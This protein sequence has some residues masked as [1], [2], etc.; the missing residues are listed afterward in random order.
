[1]ADITP[2]L[3]VLKSYRKGEGQDMQAKLS[4]IGKRFRDDMRGCIAMLAVA[5]R[6]SEVLKGCLEAGFPFT[7]Q[8][9]DVTDEAEVRNDDPETTRVIRESRFRKEYGP[10]QVNADGSVRDRSADAK[11]R[12][13]T[14]DVAVFD[15]GGRLEVDW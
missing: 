1:M 4:G 2:F 15:K 5:E 13:A 6:R 12:A 8:F 14:I 11:E 9:I 7:A 3:D 10:P